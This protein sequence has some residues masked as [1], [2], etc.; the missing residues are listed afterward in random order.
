MDIRDECR[1]IGVVSDGR[2]GIEIFANI[3]FISQIDGS[4][5]LKRTG[6]DPSLSPCCCIQCY[7]VG[8]VCEQ[9]AGK[10]SPDIE[11]VSSAVA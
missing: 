11:Y 4:S 1:R 6:L 5:D 3:P 2:I 10:G 9:I 8:E 7:L